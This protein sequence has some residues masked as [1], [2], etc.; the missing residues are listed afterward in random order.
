MT[1][2]TAYIHFNDEELVFFETLGKDTFSAGLPQL[3]SHCLLQG[4]S[5]SISGA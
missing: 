4:N 2:Q 3:T 1:I 5:E